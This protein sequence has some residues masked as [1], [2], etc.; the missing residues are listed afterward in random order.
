M[1]KIT[2][3]YRKNWTE[4]NVIAENKTKTGQKQNFSVQI[5]LTKGY[6]IT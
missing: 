3:E 6:N 4:N 1:Q 2:A 5:Y